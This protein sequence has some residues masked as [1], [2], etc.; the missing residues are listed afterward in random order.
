MLANELHLQLENVKHEERFHAHL[1]VTAFSSKR[2]AVWD[3]PDYAIHTPL[4]FKFTGFTDGYSAKFTLDDHLVYYGEYHMDEEQE[5]DG[6][7]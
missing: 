5:W 3:S 6:I 2:C 4:K 1:E 7:H